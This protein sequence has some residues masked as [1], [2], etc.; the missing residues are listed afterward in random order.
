MTSDFSFRCKSQVPGASPLG[1]PD[2]MSRVAPSSNVAS[3]NMMQKEH[4]VQNAAPAPDPAEVER[5]N[6][7]RLTREYAQAARSRKQRQHMANI[8]NPPKPEDMWICYFCEYEAI[9]K[10][11]PRGLVRQ[12]EMRDRK[13]RDQETE[14]RR[15][16]DKAKIKRKKAK[17][18]SKNG[19]QAGGTQQQHS[20]SSDPHHDSGASGETHLP[21]DDIDGWDGHG[22]HHGH[23]EEPESGA[24][25]IDSDEGPPDLFREYEQPVFSVQIENG[26]L[27]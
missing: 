4:A 2:A 9:F 20:Y 1:P 15:L 6:R 3:P 12:Y 27:G 25:D 26:P 22:G 21:P 16:L 14:R 18:A 8:Q 5:Q 11:P 24:A 7:R 10:E 19:A 23:C 13:I 17:K